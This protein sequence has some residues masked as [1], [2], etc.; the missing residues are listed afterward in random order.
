MEVP[1]FVPETQPVT[2]DVSVIICTRNP[3]R[4]Y[5][6][7]VIDSLKRQTL[8]RDRWE[9][10]IIDNGSAQKVSEYCDLS[11][12]VNSTIECEPTPGKTAALLRAASLMAGDHLLVVDDD[13]LLNE[14]Y[15]E[16][17]LR[18]SLSYPWVGAWAGS[19]R[20]EYE[21][22]PPEQF[23]PWLGGL[24]ID[25]IQRPV[26]T[27]LVRGVEASPPGA[28]MAVRRFVVQKW[29]DLARNDNLRM[30]LGHVGSNIGAGE[31]AD[32][33][34]CSL[35]FGLGT[36]RFPSMKLTHLIPA[37]KLTI[38]YLQ[39]IYFSQAYAAA[40]VPSLFESPSLIPQK[41][42]GANLRIAILGLILL[43]TRKSKVE[44]AIRMAKLTGRIA[45][46]RDLEQS[47]LT[48][49]KREPLP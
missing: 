20:P 36:G 39:S 29:A 32:M 21:S 7:R 5:F 41:P 47:L 43:L 6:E 49:P 10:L 35:Y 46:I 40:I 24:V 37:K 48:N 45:G 2:M 25:E 8:P 11:W 42:Y 33:A 28:G 17:V 3:R 14:N 16:E 34:L 18:V 15:L 1:E 26:W 19:Y 9:L 38:K 13:N 12:H 31:D 4:D 44:R 23:R 30:N 27:N 22:E